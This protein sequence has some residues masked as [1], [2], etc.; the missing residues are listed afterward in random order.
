MKLNLGDHIRSNRHRMNLTQEQL[1]EQFCTSPQAISRWEN[2]S[3]YPDI[4][5]LPMIASF[6]GTSVDALL[7]CTDEE[8]RKFC[9]DLQDALTDAT[10]K[11][12]ADRVI[13]LLRKIRCNLREYHHGY[14]LWDLF[15]ELWKTRLFKDERVL[16]EMRLLAKEVFSVYPREDHFAVIENMAN[17]ESDEQIDAFLD[18]HAVREDMTRSRLL[19]NRYKMREETD[20]IEP[21]RQFIL[22]YELEHITTA[23]NDWQPY[24]SKE[25][26]HF[27]W[28]CE[29]QLHYLNS[30]NCLVPDA[31]HLV[32]GGTSPDL[33]CEVRIALGIRY[34]RALAWLDETDA[35]LD[36]FED[37]VSIIEQIMSIQDEEF[38]M[39]CSSPALNGF[40]LKATFHRLE[41][42]RTLCL[43]SN[44]WVDWIIPEDILKSVQNDPWF[45][46]VS[47]KSKRFDLLMAR[48]KDCVQK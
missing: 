45:G 18:A 23:A 35:A 11:K 27:K 24:L 36:A 21:L 26:R 2:G 8:K 29:T 1:A 44:G 7:G 25:P 4:E 22:W 6:F 16:E 43:E 30:V 20:K 34:M 9:S 15:R 33:W 17:M 38:A 46:P 48:L 32:S 47:I 41:S 12:D 37:V 42:G 13:M 40:S 10:V 5:M 28:F 14:R 39:G 19:F 31:K 3:T